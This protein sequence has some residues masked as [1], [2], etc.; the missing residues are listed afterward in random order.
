MLKNSKTTSSKKDL[1]LS[2]DDLSFDEVKE[3]K[4]EELIAAPKPQE[5]LPQPTAKPMLDTKQHR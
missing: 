5:S 1:E 2:P 4:V 3:K